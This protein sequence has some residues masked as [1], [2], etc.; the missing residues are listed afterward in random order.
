MITTIAE[1]GKIGISDTLPWEVVVR[2]FEMEGFWVVRLESLGK[3]TPHA[4]VLMRWTH[5]GYFTTKDAALATAVG[6]IMK[7]EATRITE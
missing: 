6:L 5:H 1:G 2:V 3:K 4:G 7:G